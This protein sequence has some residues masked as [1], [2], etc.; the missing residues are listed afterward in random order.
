M[1]NR[2]LQPLAIVLVLVLTACSADESEQN[3]LPTTLT[4]PYDVSVF[5]DPDD[6][7]ANFSSQLAVY[8]GVQSQD[9]DHDHHGTLLWDVPSDRKIEFRCEDAITM[10]R[11]EVGLWDSINTRENGQQPNVVYS[12]QPPMALQVDDA[13][14]FGFTPQG[15]VEYEVWRNN[16]SG[17]V[18]VRTLLGTYAPIVIYTNSGL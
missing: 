12:I 2:L 18:G 10:L 6:T 3:N 13:I 17:N 7:P 9:T 16:S 8:Q 4:A 1:I 14:I 15:I 5:P 11:L